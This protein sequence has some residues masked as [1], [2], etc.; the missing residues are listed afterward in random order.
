M[1]QKCSCCKKFTV[2]EQKRNNK[3]YKTCTRCRKIRNSKKHKKITIEKG[4]WHI[5]W[6][7]YGKVQKV[8]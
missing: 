1:K 2:R 8:R 4:V 3:Y 7:G 6:F 5:D